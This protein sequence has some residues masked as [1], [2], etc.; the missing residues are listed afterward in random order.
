MEDVHVSEIHVT[1]LAIFNPPPP[2][3]PKPKVI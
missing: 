1:G 2:R 3:I